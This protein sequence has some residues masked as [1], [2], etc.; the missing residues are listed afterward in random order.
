MAMPH[1]VNWIGRRRYNPAQR[2]RSIEMAL[3]YV[4]VNGVMQANVRFTFD[5]QLCENTLYAR[6]GS[7]DFAGKAAGF[8]TV[9]LAELLQPMAT[10]QSNRLSYSGIHVVD[11]TSN[12][13]PIYDTTSGYPLPGGNDAQPLPNGVA[14]VVTARTALRG[15]SFRGRNYV[16]GLLP[17]QVTDSMFQ[18]GI[19]SAVLS[20]YN[21]LTEAMRVSLIPMVVVSRFSGGLPRAF[22]TATDITTWDNVSR[23]TRSQR[24][25]NPGIG[26]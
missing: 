19:V 11:L 18:A 2:D 24:R 20:H 7:T 23:G 1:L 17:S 16:A 3:P 8:A 21:A 15:R 14:L 10:H 9:I 25:R 4:P 6:W 26:S 5:G 12:S 22:G 13:G